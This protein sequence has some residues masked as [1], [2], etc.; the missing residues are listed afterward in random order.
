M[1]PGYV[2]VQIH[3]LDGAEA[4]AADGIDCEAH[5]LARAHHRLLVSRRG[6]RVRALEGG[7]QQVGIDVPINCH[8]QV[9][10]T[11]RD[12]THTPG[13]GLTEDGPPS[14]PPLTPFPPLHSP[15]N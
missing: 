7:Q 15:L 11:V 6:C 12:V 2:G 1:P 13:L 10:D 4:G 8:G 14:P 9:A 5:F 3:P